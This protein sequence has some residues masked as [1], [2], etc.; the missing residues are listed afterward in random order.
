MRVPSV[1]ALTLGLIVLVPGCGG[2][3]SAVSDTV[4]CSNVTGTIDF[5]PTLKGT[6]V[7][8][9]ANETVEFRVIGTRCSASGP[10]VVSVSAASMVGTITGGTARCTGI[11]KSSRV[12]ATVTWTPRSLGRSVLTF[13]PRTNLESGPDGGAGLTLAGNARV[14]GAFHGSR[15]RS[16]STLNL[17]SDETL[18][19]ILSDCSSTP[20]LAS[21]RVTCG[22]L[23]IVSGFA[24]M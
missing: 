3:K 15:G 17:F 11:L 1:M 18:S 9:S 23:M 20:G 16:T 12:R 8:G 21:L 6:T 4:S 2:A 10:N 7:T 19:Q 24:F 14:T 22:D 13:A 5:V